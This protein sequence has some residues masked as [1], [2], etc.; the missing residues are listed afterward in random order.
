MTFTRSKIR[1]SSWTADGMDEVFFRPQRAKW[2]EEEVHGGVPICWPWF[3]RREGAPKHGLA[4]YATWTLREKVGKTVQ[5]WRLV[6]NEATR[7]LWPHDFRL[8]YVVNVVSENRL[9]LELTA[10]NTGKEPFE[11]A[12]GF[13]PYFRVADPRKVQLDGRPVTTSPC[14]M[15]TPADGKSRLLVDRITGRTIT[16]TA[17]GNDGWFAWNPGVERTPL[18]GTLEPDEWMRFFC[19]EPYNAKPYTLRPGES[20]KLK[21]VIQVDGAIPVRKTEVASP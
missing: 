2:G 15:S 10:V 5:K 3:G 8:D 14:Q 13:H 18:C 16:L 1:T 11:A 21:L 17:E 6:S 4:R 19:V 20:R 7:R 9:S 12:G